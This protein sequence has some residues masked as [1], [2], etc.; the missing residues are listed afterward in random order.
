MIKISLINFE[1]S[2]KDKK[3]NLEKKEKH[4][5][6]VLELFPETQVVVFPELSFTGYVLDEDNKKLAEDENGFCV[7]EI[8]KLAKKY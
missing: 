3:A 5:K 7:S 4:I 8:K 2:W 1:A 6:K